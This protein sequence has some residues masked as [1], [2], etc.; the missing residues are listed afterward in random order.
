MLNLLIETTSGTNPDG[1]TKPDGDLPAPAFQPGQPSP[2][3]PK[4][5]PKLVILL[6]SALLAV[7]WQTSIVATPGYAGVPHQAA[8]APATRDRKDGTS[9]DHEPECE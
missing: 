3:G 8:S 5:M 9:G 6:L 1:G 2:T 4:T 7:M